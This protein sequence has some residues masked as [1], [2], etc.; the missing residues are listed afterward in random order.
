MNKLT[1]FELTR[2]DMRTTMV[3]CQ[4]KESEGEYMVLSFILEGEGRKLYCH[5]VVDL[6]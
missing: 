3:D 1:S 5:M 2:K 6:N 4:Q